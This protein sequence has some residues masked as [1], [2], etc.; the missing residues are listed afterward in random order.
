MAQHRYGAQD[1]RPARPPAVK[2]RYPRR[3][4]RRRRILEDHDEGVIESLHLHLPSGWRCRVGPVAGPIAQQR[5]M[6]QLERLAAKTS[7]AVPA[8]G[9]ERTGSGVGLGLSIVRGWRAP[10]AA[11]CSPRP[12]PGRPGGHG[13]AAAA[14]RAYLAGSSEIQRNI[15]AMRLRRITEP[16][17]PLFCVR[18]A[19]SARS[20]GRCPRRFVLAPEV[21]ELLDPGCGAAGLWWRCSPTAATSGPGRDAV[22]VGLS[23]RG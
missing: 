8:V 12:A 5:P 20:I 14:G 2:P 15:I 11:L 6:C 7:R 22:P 1:H 13:V 16:A 23:V 19:G 21:E 9:A 3:P 10:T 18:R 4:S 17:S